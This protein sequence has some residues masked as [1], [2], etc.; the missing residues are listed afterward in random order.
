MSRELDLT[1]QR[2]GL[3]VAQ[4]VHERT[5]SGKVYELLCDC[6]DVT[7]VK[8]GLL[9][10]GNTQSCGCLR[11]S[12]VVDKNFKHGYARRGHNQEYDAYLNAKS[13]CQDPNHKSFYNYGGRG[14]EFRFT[15]IEDWMQE[16]GIR[17]HPSLSIDRIDNNGHYEIGN[18]KWSTDKEQRA[19]QRNSKR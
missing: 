6:G 9:T 13:R 8:T 18:L 19:N 11:R 17:P 16:V 2:F 14:I 5:K 3:L 10:N 1:G 12:L 7:Y 15:S 4:S